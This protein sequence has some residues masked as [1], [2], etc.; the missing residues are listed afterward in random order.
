MASRAP[1]PCERACTR[2]A[3]GEDSFC[4]DCDMILCRDH[5][6][7]PAHTCG[8]NMVSER[9]I[10]V[11]TSLADAVANRYTWAAVM[12]VALPNV[13]CSDKLTS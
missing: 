11:R 7:D 6:D 12:Y 3:L 9:S 2:L 4:P 5:Y 1:L 10:G 8:Y 13:V